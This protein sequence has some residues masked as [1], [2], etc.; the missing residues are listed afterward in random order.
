MTW[1]EHFLQDMLRRL[2]ELTFVQPAS[3][4]STSLEHPSS[5]RAANP[6]GESF[7]ATP[8]VWG[9]HQSASE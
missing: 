8:R 4:P 1:L 3:L 6:A 5:I 9:C 7:I 2:P